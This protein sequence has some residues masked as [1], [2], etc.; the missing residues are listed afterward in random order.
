MDSLYAGAT[1]IFSVLDLEKLKTAQKAEFGPYL[2]CLANQTT[3][4]PPK[5]TDASMSY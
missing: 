3:P 2:T 1:N 4:F 5:E